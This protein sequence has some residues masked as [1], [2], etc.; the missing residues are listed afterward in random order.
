MTGPGRPKVGQVVVTRLPDDMV[1]RLDYWAKDNNMTRA[2][3]IR[4]ML[5]VYLIANT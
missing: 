2:E 1:T 4:H 3:A 5:T